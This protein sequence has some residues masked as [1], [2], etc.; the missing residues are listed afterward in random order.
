[1]SNQMYTDTTMEHFKF[2]RNIG[3]MDDAD[4]VGMVGDPACGD[5]LT[6]YIKVADEVIQNISYLIFGCAAAIASGSMTT[7]LAKGKSIEAAMSITEEDISDELGGLPDNKKHCS[8]LGVK[9]LRSAI[10]DYY[11]RKERN[12]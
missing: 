7:E 1:M 11:Y 5:F 2:P 3:R 4:G 12:N 10:E 6:I 8:N 9:A